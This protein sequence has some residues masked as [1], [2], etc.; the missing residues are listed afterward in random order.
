[1]KR[2][3]DNINSFNNDIRNIGSY[4][5]TKNNIYSA[6][7]ANKRLTDET[8]RIIKTYFKQKIKI[9]DIGCGDGTYTLELYKAI[10]PKQITGFDFAE[11]AIKVADKNAKKIKNSSVIFKTCDIYNINRQFG[12]D[13]Y[14]L[15]IARGVLHHIHNP[16]I[17]V[18]EICKTTSKIIVL[19]PN[20]YNPILKIIEKI[21]RY[22]VEH[23]EKS[24]FPPLLNKWFTKQ[25]FK[26][27]EQK[28]IGL[29]PY[30]FP[31][32]LAKILKTIGPFFEKIPYISKFYL[33]SNIL[34]LEKN[35]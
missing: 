6:L 10:K 20:G 25:G 17:A 4:V 5:Y 11:D 33:A 29:V 14:D 26:V 24:Y 23:G 28:Y 27:T 3:K 2:K 15:A 13:N 9:I 22:H 18:R 34:Y 35:H 7:T 21:S 31:E 1:M 12:K 32:K 8:I 30:F 19:E 16:E